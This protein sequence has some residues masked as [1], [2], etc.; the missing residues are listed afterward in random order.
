MSAA[1]TRAARLAQ[2]AAA[3][4]FKRAFSLIHKV[5]SPVAAAGPC[6]PAFAA[7]GRRRVVA[8]SVKH[9]SVYEQEMNSPER[10]TYPVSASAARKVQCA[11]MGADGPGRSGIGGQAPVGARRPPRNQTIRD[12][13]TK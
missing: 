12:E 5:T 10:Q 13:D 7:G 6:R 1:V 9:F 11:R 8:S 4:L 2:P 3:F